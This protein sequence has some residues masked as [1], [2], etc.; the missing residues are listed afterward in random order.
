MI[1]LRLG[2]EDLADTRFAVSALAE[3]V[4]S[5]RVWLLPGYYVLQLPWLRQAR[6]ALG[7]LDI[8]P[9]LALVGA[10]R[11]VPDFLT[12]RPAEP[13]A[14]FAAELERVRAVPPAKV[15][16][17]VRAALQGRP[18]P[19][20]LA[21]GLARPALLRDRLA[22]LLQDYWSVALEPH[23]PRMRG[24][25]EADMLYRAQQLTRGGARLLF[26]DL[27]RT[28]GWRDGMLRLELSYPHRELTIP[29]TGRG[30][31]LMP[32]LFVKTPGLPLDPD[33][34]PTVLYPARGIATVWETAPPPPP[35][36]LAA[37]L[38]RP[39]AQILGCLDRPAS[40]TD[41]ARRLGVTPGAVS[42]HL[43][44]LHGAGLVAKARTGRSVL[45]ARTGTG[46]RLLR[47]APGG[48]GG[49]G[50]EDSR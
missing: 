25:L 13:V 2:V 7:D 49:F 40:T 10:H 19:P 1:E 5:L 23:W 36:V 30:V 42:Q 26:A 17:D 43:A 50:D 41:L 31:C 47:G 27:H 8:G 16:A 21:G 28:I 39:K 29:V 6:A 34:P 24:V 12:A 46:D 9:L 44:V 3:T 48:F 15:A 33:E 45:Y 18:V 32:A 22:E 14:E 11:A 38:G 20:V 35:G 4:L 37:L